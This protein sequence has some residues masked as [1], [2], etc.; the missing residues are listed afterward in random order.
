[1]IS[2]NPNQ[3][4]IWTDEK[5]HSWR[6]TYPREALLADDIALM[7]SDPSGLRFYRWCA[8]RFNE[9][10][11]RQIA[12]YVHHLPDAS[13]VRSR[14]ALFCTILKRGGVNQYVTR[15]VRLDHGDEL[16]TV[17]ASRNNLAD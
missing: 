10:F 5:E 17:V 6:A 15:Q 2:T 8:L 16:S 7:L 1:M 9:P 4:S 14:G 13:I 3:L 11:L 12:A